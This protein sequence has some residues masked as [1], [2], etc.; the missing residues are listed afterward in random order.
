MGWDD[1]NK[2]KAIDENFQFLTILVH[3]T[4][5]EIEVMHGLLLTSNYVQMLSRHL[6]GVLEPTQ[7]L[8]HA[9]GCLYTIGEDYNITK[10]IDMNFQFL[11]I[12]VHL[13][14]VEVEVMYGPLLTS[15]DVQ[16][17]S[18]RLTG[19]L[20]PIQTLK[21]ACQCLYMSSR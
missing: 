6:L 2:T 8:Y 17:L 20:E 12:L 5:V 3:L 10:A 4:P 21:H 1:H 7:T 16:M 14:P 19:V 15:N 18:R 9:F 13:T 11:T